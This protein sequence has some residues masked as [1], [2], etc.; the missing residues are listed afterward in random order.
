M[1]VIG[2]DV[3]YGAV[4]QLDEIT[5]TGDSS[6]TMFLNGTR[7]TTNIAEQLIVSVNGVIQK[8][9]SAYT[10]LGSTITFAEALDSADDTIDFITV[11]GNAYN[12]ATVS[13]G[14]ITAD[15]LSN[16]ISVTSTPIR[17]NASSVSQSFTID[18]NTNG[19]VAGPITFDSGTTVTLNGS[20]TIV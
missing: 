17:K 13:D 8:P 1:S 7:Q 5:P 14:A 3:Q 11:F 19:L 15:K 10:V 4:T 20:L 6:Y 18:S 16:A 9:N 12:V 2:N